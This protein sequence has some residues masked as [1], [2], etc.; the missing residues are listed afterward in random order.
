MECRVLIV[1]GALVVLSEAAQITQ[2]GA[3]RTAPPA[4]AS[5]DQKPRRLDSGLTEAAGVTLSVVDKDGRPV[6]GL[7]K[8]DFT[9][10][11]DG[12]EWPIYSVDDLCE[13]EGRPSGDSP[14]IAG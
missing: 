7:K 8:E 1:L 2:S 6:R 12:K 3:A 13:A 10:Y 5:E 9:V 11:V 4:P 14:A